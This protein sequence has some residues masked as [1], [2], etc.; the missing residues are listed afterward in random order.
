M[1]FSLKNINFFS[2][3][4]F[5]KSKII[6]ISY[7]AAGVL[8][9]IANE[10]DWKYYTAV[11][12]IDVLEDLRSII[13]LWKL[14]SEE[15]IRYKSLNIFVDLLNSNVVPEAQLWAIWGLLHIRLTNYGT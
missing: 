1:L 6:N 13:S 9:L 3:R 8:A 12:K 10:N 7:L 5:L 15:I 14:P 11:R 2:G 4:F